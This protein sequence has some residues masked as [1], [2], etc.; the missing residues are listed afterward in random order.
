M[1]MSVIKSHQPLR[2]SEFFGFAINSILYQ[3]G[4]YPPEQFERVQKYG[5]PMM[6]TCDD[7]LKS[8]ITSVMKQL[9]GLWQAR[10]AE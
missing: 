6:V 9:E 7:A 5:L 3:R 8:Y 2:T 10:I 4:V 1:L